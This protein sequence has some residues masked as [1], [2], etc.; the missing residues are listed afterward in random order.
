MSSKNILGVLGHAKRVVAAIE[1]DKLRLEED[2]A[3][4]LE[5]GGGGLDAAEASWVKPLL[6]KTFTP[7]AALQPGRE[8]GAKGRGGERGERSKTYCLPEPEQS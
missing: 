4:D 7:C 3:P 1:G 5:V 2:I 8:N 6:A